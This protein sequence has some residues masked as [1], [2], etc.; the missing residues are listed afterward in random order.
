M[1]PFRFLTTLLIPIHVIAGEINYF[2][3]KIDFWG[4]EA[5]KPLPTKSTKGSETGNDKFPWKTYLDPKN[6]EFFK[7]GDYTP[8]EP[9]MEVARNPTDENIKHWFDLMKKKNEIQSRLQARMQEYIAKNSTVKSNLISDQNQGKAEI[10]I[11]KESKKVA[12]DPSRFKLRMYFE[13]TCP[14]CRKMFGVLKRLQD[15]GY[16]VEALQIDRGPVS[17]REKVVPIAKAEDSEIQRHNINGVPFLL[18][19]DSKR[20]ALLPPIQGY[21]GYEEIKNLLKDASK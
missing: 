10:A 20:R 4:E 18:I 3:S 11:A 8:P 6:N 12:V 21:H 9:F 5:Q 14:H 17:E 15:E 7:E 13:S 16:I 2:D 1:R 19:A